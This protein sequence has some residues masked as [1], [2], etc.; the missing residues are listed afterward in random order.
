M[1]ERVERMD[2]RKNHISSMRMIYAQAYPTAMTKT[3]GP[4]AGKTPVKVIRVGQ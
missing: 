1:A 3:T 2:K 4:T